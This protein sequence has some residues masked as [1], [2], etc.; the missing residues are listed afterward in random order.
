MSFHCIKLFYFPRVSSTSNVFEIHQYGVSEPI[1]DNYLFAVVDIINMNLTNAK[2]E[3]NNKYSFN[4]YL[5]LK[6]SLRACPHL[7]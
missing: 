5:N 6:K 2:S 4:F 1:T 7:Q 3:E